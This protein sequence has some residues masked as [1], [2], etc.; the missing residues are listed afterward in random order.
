MRWILG[1]FIVKMR[2]QSIIY[3]STSLHTGNGIIIIISI[4]I[5][6]SLHGSLQNDFRSI[7]DLNFVHQ[8]ILHSLLTLSSK[9]TSLSHFQPPDLNVVFEKT[10]DGDIEDDE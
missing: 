1:L 7:E 2:Y 5:T 10:G 9:T 4:N 3:I 8:T 6:T